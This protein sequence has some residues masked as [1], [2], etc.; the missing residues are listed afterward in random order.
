[1]QKS[2]GQVQERVKNWCWTQRLGDIFLNMTDFLKVYIQYVNNYNI[3][4][5]TLSQLQQ[6]TEFQQFIED[7]QSRPECNNL[8]I[9]SY[10]IM[11]IQRIPR[12]VLLLEDLVKHTPEGHIDNAELVQALGKMK[13]VARLINEK[14]A[15]SENFSKLLSIYNRLDPK[16]DNLCEAHRHFIKEGIIKLEDT[17]PYNAFLFS[18]IML[19]TKEKGPKKLKLKMN[20]TLRTANVVDVADNKNT[21]VKNF[22]Q[23]TTPKKNILMQTKTQEEKDEWM[24]AIAQCVKEQIDKGKSFI[25]PKSEE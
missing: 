18:D 1:M 12:Y 11:P 7:A 24:K 17:N 25:N 10:L 2:K 6:V 8:D 16:V 13:Q 20:I 5:E 3:A 19:V 22:F 4:L 21:K 15:E 9:Y 14:K 23:L